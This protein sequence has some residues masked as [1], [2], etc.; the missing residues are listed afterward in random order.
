METINLAGIT[1]DSIV[2]GPGLRTTIFTQGCPHA[3][4]GCHNPET[5]TFTD[6]DRRDVEQ[7]IKEIVSSSNKAVTFSGGEPFSQAK[8]C[9]KIAKRLKDS[10]FNLWAYSG[11]KFEELLNGSE[12]QVNFLKQLDVLVDGKFILEQKSLSLLYKGSRNQRVINVQKSLASDTIILYEI[13]KVSKE[14]SVKLFI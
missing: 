12:D 6:N 2:D 11:Y 9:Y 8:A 4:P 1:L 14:S 7:V 10:G 5:W 3:C 13:E